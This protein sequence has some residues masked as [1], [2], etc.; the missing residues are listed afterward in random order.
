MPK[1]IMAVCADVH[2]HPHAHKNT[3][4]ENGQSSRVTLTVR[5]LEEFLGYCSEQDIPGFIAG[6]LLHDKYAVPVEVLKPLQVL[7]QNSQEVDVTVVVGNHERPDRFSQ[8]TT[9]SCLR[10]W[11]AVGSPDAIHHVSGVDVY[12]MP[13]FPDFEK[14]CAKLRDMLSQADPNVP[15]ILI[16]HGCV[17]GARSDN[18]FTLSNPGLTKDMLWLSAFNLTL[19]GD[20]HKHQAIDVGMNAWYVGALTPQTFGERHNASGFVVV[21]DDLSFERIEINSGPRF[22]YGVNSPDQPLPASVS[23]A[24]SDHTET[25]IKQDPDAAAETALKNHAGMQVDMDPSDL[26][27]MVSAYYQARPPVD[28][29][30]HKGLVFAYL[31]EILETPR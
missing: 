2:M 29:T 14:P 5:A 15:R 6:D 10:D 7:Q 13:W 27:S 19:F 16:G 9:L 3:Y 20:I 21:N 25:F 24:L 11:V 30:L 1:P 12:F 22:A 28:A 31:S 17:D 8:T 18:G 23:P 26:R 4:D